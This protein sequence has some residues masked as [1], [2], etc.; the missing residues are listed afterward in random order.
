MEH[1]RAEALHAA[2]ARAHAD[3]R[4]ARAH[5]LRAAYHAGFGSE[6]LRNTKLWQMLPKDLEWKVLM[7]T[8]CEAAALAARGRAPARRL[9]LYDMYLKDPVAPERLVARRHC[10]LRPEDKAFTDS[11]NRFERNC[12]ARNGLTSSDAR[13]NSLTDTSIKAVMK[14]HKVA[15]CN[16]TVDPP[17][18][19][20][21]VSGVSNMA[22]LFAGWGEFNQPIGDWDTSNVKSMTRMFSRAGTFNQPIGKWKTASV[23]D[24]SFMFYNASA[25]NQPIGDWDTS[26]VTSMD[27]M[28]RDAMAFDQPIGRWRTQ[29]VTGMSS[30]FAGARMFN[31]PL[32]F[33]TSAVVDMSMMLCDASAFNQT[34]SFNTARVT[35]M[36][37]M[38]KDADAFNNGNAPLVLNTTAAVEMEEMLMRTPAF[39]QTVRFDTRTVVNM[40]RMFY[41]AGK[42]NNGNR[43]LELSTALVTNMSEMLRF[44]VSFNQ[45]ANLTDMGRVL[46][47]QHMLP[48]T[49][50]RVFTRDVNRAAAGFDAYAGR[51]TV[52]G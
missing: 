2:R 18:G 8:G 27:S 29:K 13:V 14:E 12:A 16:G 41:D 1:P 5:A 24:M 50:A 23:N 38:F 39:N 43:P 34:V 10:T 17:I 4:K 45:R 25:F 49:D 19:E 35:D 26:T 21:D 52:T 40:R 47:V 42:F 11:C 46:D 22:G 36:R 44:A 28:F 3:P 30:M 51:I 31:R 37:M 32:A 33:D 20:W 48:N 9:E 15:I 6:A 7:E